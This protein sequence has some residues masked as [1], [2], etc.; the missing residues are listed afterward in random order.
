M[1]ILSVLGAAWQ[2]F[3][4]IT[5]STY[6]WIAFLF[7][8]W[9]FLGHIQDLRDIEGDRQSGSQNAKLFLWFLVKRERV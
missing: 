7:G 2:I 6:Q 1:G 9:L 8:T 4:V 3:N 5:P